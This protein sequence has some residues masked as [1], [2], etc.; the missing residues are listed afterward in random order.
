MSYDIILS[1]RGKDLILI[2][3]YT[4]SQQTQRLWI[5]TKYPRC[6]AK[7]SRNVDDS[8]TILSEQHNHSADKIVKTHDGKLIRV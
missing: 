5:C 8:V 6:K 7:I 3:G 2:N 4:F 1:R